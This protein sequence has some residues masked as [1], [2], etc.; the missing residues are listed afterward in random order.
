LTLRSP[1]LLNESQEE[2]GFITPKCKTDR[3]RQ[4]STKKKGTHPII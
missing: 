3:T 1:F 2:T 4:R